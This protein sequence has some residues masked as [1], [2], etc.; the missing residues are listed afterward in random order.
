[1]VLLLRKCKPESRLRP[2]GLQLCEPLKR[3]PSFLRDDAVVREHG[4]LSEAGQ[5][6]RRLSQQ[7][8]RVPVSLCG[9]TEPP[10][11]KVHRCDHVPT[12]PVLRMGPQP[13]LDLRD[14]GID[15]RLV[16][17]RCH[18]LS[19]RLPRQARRAKRQIKRE[20]KD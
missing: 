9:L 18:T 3:P 17:S 20:R 1:A 10:L 15:G 7:A 11:P 13:F 19:V 14:K 8:N 2:R 6:P 4:R 12:L 16:G 5:P